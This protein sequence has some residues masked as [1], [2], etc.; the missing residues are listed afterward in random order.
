MLQEAIRNVLDRL[1]NVGTCPNGHEATCPAH[2]DNK[3]SL[4]I[5]QGDDGRV[6]LH[7]HAGCSPIEIC[8]ALGM[9]ISELFPP[10]DGSGPGSGEIV[11]TYDYRDA[12]GVLLFQVVRFK[13]KDFRV[14]RPDGTG[15]E[16]KLGHTPRVLYRL[17][18][19]LAADPAEW[20]FICEGE[21]DV[22]RVRSLGLVATCNPGGAGKWHR[23]SDDSALAGRRVVILQ[24]YNEPGETGKRPGEEHAKT[25]ALHMRPIASECRIVEFSADTTDVSEWLDNSDADDLRAELLQL[26]ESADQ[27]A[28]SKNP[29]ILIDTVEHRAVTETIVALTAD[30]NLYQRSGFL[31]RIIRD[32]Q[33]SDDILRS[34]GS[35]TIQ[36][37]PVPS[38]RERITKFAVFTKIN[39][40][41]DE[42]LTHPTGWLVSAVDARAEWSGI[43]HL[44]GVSDTPVLRS[45]GS[46]WQTSG[47]DARTGVLFEPVNGTAFPEIHV[48]INIDDAT[49]AVDTL[50]EIIADFPMPSDDHKAAWLAALLTP[51]ARFAFAGPSPMFLIDANV[52]G[53]GKS[54]LAQTI[55]HVVLGREM[56]AS[57]YVHDGDEMRKKLTSIAIAGD[58]MILLDNIDGPFGNDAIDRA[59]TSTRWKDRI[60]GKSEEIELP[61]IPAWYATGNNVQVTGDMMRRVVHIRIDCLSERPEERSG[62]SHG[63]LLSWIDSNRGRLL[64]AA[65]T[66]LSAFLQRGHR[67]DLTPF[68]SF[69]GWSD[70]VRQAVVWVGMPDPCLTRRQ[71]EKSADVIGDALSQLLEAWAKYDP[72]SHGLILT[73]TMTSLFASPHSQGFQADV[74]DAMRDAIENLVGVAPGKTPNARQLGNRLR[75]LRRRVVDG[76]YID[77]DAQVG[78][79]GSRWRLFDTKKTEV[80]K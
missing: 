26:V 15:W 39:S 71:L 25:V 64:A 72:G 9:S 67:A 61:L 10:S 48:D 49:E 51:L 80:E 79:H 52:R 17:P 42:I 31:A 53:A 41:G 75:R 36:V 21:K 7:C 33:P 28:A 60:L 74:D 46:I 58:R 5:A 22:D 68:G 32:N 30:P 70:V 29:V 44:M 78:R 54:L 40:K 34:E 63:N 69:E 59:L 2:K 16:W 62:F 3:P 8:Q 19:L 56:P 57:S 76:R 77:T 65:M 1:A 13:P 35:P 4:S 37:L 12:A 50:M 6:L 73:S 20:V 24:D 27:S 43:R 23:L 11:A 45:D 47:Y 14:R 38:L 66:V 18:E 55:G